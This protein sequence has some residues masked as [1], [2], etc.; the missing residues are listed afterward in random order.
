MKASIPRSTP[1]EAE[2]AKPAK[3]SQSP[4]ST[5]LTVSLLTMSDELT[6][7]TEGEDMK[8]K[9]PEAAWSKRSTGQVVEGFICM[10]RVTDPSMPQLRR[11]RNQT[12]LI[13]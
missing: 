3:N 11:E 12:P 5:N 8:E 2:I 1:N 10:N 13:K 6:L 4:Y 7:D 9:K